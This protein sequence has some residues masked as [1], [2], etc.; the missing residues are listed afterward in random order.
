MFY[1][2][3]LAVCALALAVASSYA[4]AADSTL[5]TVIVSVKRGGAALKDTTTGV[6]VRNAKMQ[7][8][9]T[10]GAPRTLLVGARYRFAGAGQ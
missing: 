2:P 10:A 8:T 4:H 9:Y 5:D 7:D 3:N 6:G 1:R